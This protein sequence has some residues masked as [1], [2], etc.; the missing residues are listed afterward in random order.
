[1]LSWL[2]YLVARPRQ[3]ERVEFDDAIVRR[4]MSDGRVECVRWAE[5]RRIEV[6]TTDEGPF[7]EDVFWLLFGETG[8]VVAPSQTAGTKALVD[9][10]LG[11]PRVDS[12]AVVDAMAS[13]ENARFV[14]WRR[15]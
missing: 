14:V 11:M 6:M 7:V 8:G 3:I 15:E 9:H 5:L 12:Q 2:R 1:M 10:I 13:H 4:T